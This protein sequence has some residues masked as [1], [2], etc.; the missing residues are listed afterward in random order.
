MY[1][2]PQPRDRDK[3]L[4]V[5]GRKTWQKKRDI[6]ITEDS[7]Y[8]HLEEEPQQEDCLGD[9]QSQEQKEPNLLYHPPHRR[10]D[11]PGRDKETL[12]LIL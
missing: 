6:L 10:G 7:V 3:S 1:P 11:A 4:P 9:Q 8:L 12:P 2:P 5:P